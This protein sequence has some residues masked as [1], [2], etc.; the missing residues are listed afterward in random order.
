MDAGGAPPIPESARW[1][2]DRHAALWQQAVA[3]A[4]DAPLVVLDGDPF[5]GL[6]YNPVFTDAGWPG[7][8]VVAPIYREH[9]MRGT[10]SFPDLYVVLVAT[11]AQLRAR[12]SA[13]ATRRR[14]NFEANLRLLDPQR[15]YFAA[16]AD[17]EPRRVLMLETDDRERLVANVLDAT[18]ALP[19]GLPDSAT[20][21]AHMTRWLGAEEDA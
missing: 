18:G 9:V 7:A 1:F 2:V 14:R 4:T 17:S 15:G 3:L 19:L 10:L 12:R 11:E 6:W 20:L 5:K 8:R 13:D 16:M 21:L